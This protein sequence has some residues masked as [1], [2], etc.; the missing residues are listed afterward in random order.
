MFLQDKGAF[1]FGAEKGFTVEAVKKLQQLGLTSTATSLVEMKVR[2]GR[3]TSKTI[4]ANELGDYL[5]V[6]EVSN[7]MATIYVLKL[8][9]TSK[10]GK[11][12]YSLEKEIHLPA[13]GNEEDELERLTSDEWTKKF[14]ETAPEFNRVYHNDGLGVAQGA[15]NTVNGV[16]DIVVGLL[17]TPAAIT[18]TIIWAEEQVGILDEDPNFRVGYIAFYDW[19]RGLIIDEYGEE[20]AWNDSHGWS[21]FIGGSSVEILTGAYIEKIGLFGKLFKSLGGKGASSADEVAEVTAAG[22]DETR[23]LA[24]NIDDVDKVKVTSWAEAGT[25]PDLNPGR[26][27]QIGGPTPWNYIKTGLWGGKFELGLSRNF[28]WVFKWTNSN[29]PIS[30]YVSEFVQQSQLM[31]PRGWEYIKGILGQRIV[32]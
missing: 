24:S 10:Q 12:Y 14:I 3:G 6:V 22:L 15:A 5:T 19:S 26:W 11:Q 20:G 21:K 7:G 30:N 32:K 16:Q 25:T 31:W 8:T 23:S 9:R 18:N 29:A 27:V 28:P 2:T 13:P 4:K 1:T 17:N